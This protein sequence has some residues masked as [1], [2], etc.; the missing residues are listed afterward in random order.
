MLQVRRRRRKQEA[1]R[2]GAGSGV[3]RKGFLHD[4]VWC[5]GTHVTRTSS[6]ASMGSIE[7]LGQMYSGKI[8]ASDSEKVCTLGSKGRV[9]ISSPW[10]MPPTVL[11]FGFLLVGLL[12][13]P[14]A[15][16]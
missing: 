13:F 4:A 7:R 16:P 8:Q 15:A 5:G 12:G 11:L 3:A 6:S 10:V 2:E 9:R 14:P 1:A